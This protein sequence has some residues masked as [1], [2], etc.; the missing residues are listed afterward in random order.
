M[1]DEDILEF[2]KMY[3][4]PCPTIPAGYE[5]AGEFRAVRRGE[6]YLSQ[7]LTGT[8]KTY[9][10]HLDENWKDGWGKRLILI[11]AKSLLGRKW[12]RPFRS[13]KGQPPRPIVGKCKKCG[14]E[15]YESDDCYY[16]CDGVG[17]TFASKK[18]YPEE[19]NMSHSK[20]AKNLN[21]KMEFYK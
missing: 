14:V 21:E 12:K 19:D 2:E 3:H 16:H 18:C 6:Y 17:S 7:P 1:N 4:S 10:Y 5:S 15:L 20:E 8:A 13:A 11:P 9:A